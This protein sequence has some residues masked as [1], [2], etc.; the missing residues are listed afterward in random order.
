[1]S[2]PAKKSELGSAGTN[3]RSVDGE[4]RRRRSSN[5]LAAVAPSPEV[6]STNAS[7]S[8]PAEDSRA[9]SSLSSDTS[10]PPAPPVIPD[11]DDLLGEYDL[12]LDEEV[13]FS[14]ETAFSTLWIE[15]DKFSLSIL[16]AAGATNISMPPWEKKTVS[17]TAVTK[18]DTFE[19]S[20]LVS[21]T[22]N[23]KYMVGP[24]VIPTAQTQR[25]AYT[26]GSRLVVSTTTCV[27]DIPYCDYFRVEHRWVFSATKKRDFCLIES[28][29]V[30]EAKDAIQAWINAAVEATKQRGSTGNNTASPVGVSSLSVKTAESVTEQDDKAPKGLAEQIA[31]DTSSRLTTPTEITPSIG[32]ALLTHLHPTLQVAIIVCALMFI[33]TM[34]RVCAA[35]D[36]MQ[37][38]T[39]ESLIQ[40]RQQQELLKELLTKLGNTKGQ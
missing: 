35:M 40:Q 8:T 39:R 15:S 12:L 19:A 34:Y 25:Y 4:S 5:D 10:V 23:K 27:S 38:L 20:R 28:T 21:Y 13:A 36:Q 18:T 29:T 14:V 37:A 9:P 24:S 3:G 7:D 22:H 17:Y 16:D 33:Y 11:K 26:P 6:A 30:S 2:D 32:G 1:M 31:P